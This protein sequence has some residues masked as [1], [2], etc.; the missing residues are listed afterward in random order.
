HR[1]INYVADMM[2]KKYGIPWIKVNFIGAEA[3]AKSLRKIAQYYGDQKLIDQVEKVIAEEMPAVAKV[4][5]EIRPRTQG[6][7]AMLFVGGSRAHHYQE[8]FKELGMET[9]SAGYEFAHR[10]DYEGRKV[11]PSI[12]VDADSRNIQELDVQPDP[13]R[14]RPRKSTEYLNELVKEGF[15]LKDY[16]G[17]M[18]D[19]PDETLIVDDISQYETE[20]MIEL[21]HPDI[22]C[23]GI[24]EKYIVQKFGIPMKQL[25]SYDYGGP[26]AGF[27]G[28][29]NFYRE[30][31]R[32][33]NSKVWHYMKAPWQIEP[34]LAATYAWE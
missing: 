2:E 18:P 10:D 15:D 22:F 5:E 7:K 31:D 24:K 19:M 9:I 11:L 27:K 1:S 28:A 30:I 34:E 3:S 23:A 20:K 6:K 33:V 32:M 29:V 17:M 8:L 21:Y 4:I 12:V 26:Y 14:Y 16:E 13:T 25:H